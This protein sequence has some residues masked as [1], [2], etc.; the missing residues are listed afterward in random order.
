MQYPVGVSEEVSYEGELA[1]VIARL[2]R[3]VPPQRVKDVVLGFTCANDVTAR[4]VQRR[5]SQWGRAK[6]FDTFCPI[7]PWVATDVDPADLAITTTVNGELQAGRPDLADG[8]RHRRARL[9]R[10]HG[11][12][13]AAGRRHPHRHARRRRTARRSATRSA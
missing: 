8:A 4:D 10:Q 12:D 1:V 6:G 13:A 9:A 3:E 11:H 7:G 5:E 2:C